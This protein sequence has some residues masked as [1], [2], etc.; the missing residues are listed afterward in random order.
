MAAADLADAIVGLVRG[1]LSGTVLGGSTLVGVPRR[2]SV[3]GIWPE[4]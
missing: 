2:P 1:N 4:E 3:V